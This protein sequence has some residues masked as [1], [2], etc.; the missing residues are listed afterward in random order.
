MEDCSKFLNTTKDEDYSSD[1]S[2]GGVGVTDEIVAFAMDI[3]MQFEIWLDFSFP[4]DEDD[5]KD[6]HMSDAQQDHVLAIKDQVPRLSTLRIKLCPDY[7]TKITFW[8]IYFVVW[9]LIPEHNV[10]KL[11][12]TPKIYFLVLHLILEHNIAKVLFTPKILRAK[13]LLTHEL[14]N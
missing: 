10:V 2:D 9:H 8:K 1:D 5:G 11:L 7:M 14:K 6:F 4:N 12:S 13:S 3:V